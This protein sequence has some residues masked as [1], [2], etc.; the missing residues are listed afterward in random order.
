M[1]EKR[2]LQNHMLQGAAMAAGL[3]VGADVLIRERAQLKD[4]TYITR[5]VRRATVLVL[6][7]HHFYCLL[8]NGRK[9]SFRYN[10]FLG[11]EARLICL[12]ERNTEKQLFP[13]KNPQ[14]FFFVISESVE[15]E[16]IFCYNT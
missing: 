3:R 14:G 13:Q 10:E 11:D 9:E 8:A 5:R 1:R 15:V 2:R 6:Y 4:G 7:E 16:D 12:K